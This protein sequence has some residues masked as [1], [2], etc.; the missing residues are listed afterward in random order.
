MKFNLGNA[1]IV[2]VLLL[3]LYSCEF[4]YSE[5]K[6]FDDI[7]FLIENDPKSYLLKLT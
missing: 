1:V 2:P 4:E 6:N 3:L 5:N 7:I